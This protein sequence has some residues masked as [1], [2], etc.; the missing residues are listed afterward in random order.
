MRCYVPVTVSG[1][2][3][4]SSRRWFRFL[5]PAVLLAIVL[6]AGALARTETATVRSY[7]DG[8]WWSLSLVTT[9]GFVGHAPTTTV[10]KIVSALLMVMGFSLM[11]M[12]T[13]AIASL[14]V[15]EDE[16]PDDLR[17][18]AFEERVMEELRLLRREV[19]DLH[20]QGRIGGGDG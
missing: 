3:V 6:A 1:K 11:A 10:G 13:A 14:F 5:A 4:S 2:I 19:S 18:R 20:R 9:V 8:L 16:L 17:E 12:T 15:R 7:W